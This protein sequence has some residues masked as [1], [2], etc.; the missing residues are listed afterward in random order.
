MA[1]WGIPF[2]HIENEWTDEQF[3]L[4]YRM[5]ADRKQT[6]AKAMQRHGKKVKPYVD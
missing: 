2:D 3:M 4:M 1:E 5:L 6:E